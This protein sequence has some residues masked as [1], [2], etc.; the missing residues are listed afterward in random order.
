M[1]T[2]YIYKSLIE[3]IFISNDIHFASSFPSALAITSFF[4]LCQAL[5]YVFAPMKV[6]EN[7]Y[8]SD[9]YDFSKFDGSRKIKV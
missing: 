3:Q 8:L 1:G 4:F 9:S 5:A 2:S 6:Y 7:I